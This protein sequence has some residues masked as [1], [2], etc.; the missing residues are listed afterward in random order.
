MGA[1][2]AV[3]AIPYRS[4]KE[5]IEKNRKNKNQNKNKRQTKSAPGSRSPS[6]SKS[7]V[8]DWKNKFGREDST[9]VNIKKSQSLGHLPLVEVPRA[10]LSG[11]SNIACGK[12]KGIEEPSLQKQTTRLKTTV[13]RDFALK[14]TVRVSV[15]AVTGLERRSRI[16]SVAGGVTERRF[17]H[18]STSDNI[19]NENNVSKDTNTNT[20]SP[21]Q[22][23]TNATNKM[24]SDED[25]MAFLNK[26]N[27]D[28][29]AGTSTTAGNY[30]KKAEYKTM[31]DEVD[32]PAV[33]V[34]ATKDAWYISDADEPFV[35]VALKN[36][37][38]GL[39]DEETF[40]KLIEHPSP[41][42]AAE[43]IQILDIGD[44][45]PRGEYRDIVK[46]VRE[47]CKGGDVR[48]YRVP[49]E[50]SRVEYWVVGVEGERLVGAKA[51]GVES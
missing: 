38:K 28:P 30:R 26:A 36:E 41:A 32:V 17:F 8:V 24:A 4:I 50:G 21:E 33:L 23:N 16:G 35:V 11:V 7:G 2:S 1:L 43:E 40:A 14:S 51:L 37:G 29:G 12:G 39:P 5:S 31:D 48:V 45:D 18:S 25:Y 20:S 15:A 42:D 6:I 3:L 47:A 27:E 49:G 46:A 10:E 22:I 44:W 19:T 13:Q 9:S 34:R